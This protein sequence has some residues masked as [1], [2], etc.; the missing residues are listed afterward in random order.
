MNVQDLYIEFGLEPFEKVA[1]GAEWHGPCPVC[2]GD[3]RFVIWRERKRAGGEY[4]CRDCGVW[5]D[6]VQFQV[7]FMGVDY[8]EA[9]AR[10]GRASEHS[11]AQRPQRPPP[12][13]HGREIVKP[14]NL[15]IEKAGK[16]VEYAHEQLLKD[17][18]ILAYLAG[19]GINRKSAIKHRL[20]FNPG[21]TGKYH[22]RPRNS[23]ALP[24]KKD[25]K[26]Q[27]KKWLWFP[28]G[29]VIPNFCGSQVWSLQI[30][31]P[32]GF[33]FGPRYVFLEGGSN[34]S[35]V[36]GPDRAA[37]VVVEAR[38]CAIAVYQA[39]GD[40]VG[41]FAAQTVLGHPD[42]RT[43]KLFTKATQILN[44]LDYE[45]VDEVVTDGQK[46][47]LRAV[48]RWKKTYPHCDRWPVTTAKDPGDAVKKGLDLRQWVISGLAPVILVDHKLATRKTTEERRPS[49]L[50]PDVA[51]LK[52]LLTSCPVRIYHAP[53][54]VDLIDDV[55]GWRR[56]NGQS[57]GRISKLVFGSD[58]IDHLIENNPDKW[59][60]GMNLVSNK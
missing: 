17:P 4:W 2:G 57:F 39:A 10:V 21:K 14:S 9:F 45:N 53:D 34:A 42:T 22:L 47:G 59:I 43:H 49:R 54:R 24:E 46:A 30:R 7:E 15:W 18:K 60:T 31:Q 51:E 26:S 50:H 41:V 36:L 55:P 8:K 35:F 13:Y 33:E 52:S 23:W 28:S 16:F 44:A 29:I 27:P 40:L 20:G 25:N 1:G 6:N 12:V 32:D 48:K 11:P 37:F 38:L 5:G 3:K 56:K 19:R 58:I